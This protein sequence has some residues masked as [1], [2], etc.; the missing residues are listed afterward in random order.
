[1]NL[2]E[3]VL[4][5]ILA[6]WGVELLALLVLGVRGRSRATRDSELRPSA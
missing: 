5:I 2:L 4:W 1:M 6:F 3:I